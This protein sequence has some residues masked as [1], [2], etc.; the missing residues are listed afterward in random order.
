MPDHGPAV[1]LGIDF[2]LRRIGM[3]CGNT[4][5][6]TAQ[7]LETL[8]HDGAPFAALSRIIAQWQP[9]RIIV[10]LPLGTDGGETD[11]SGRTRRFAAELRERHPGL[12]VTLHDERFTSRAAGSRFAEARREG[13]ARRRDAGNLDSMAAA[14]IVESWLAEQVTA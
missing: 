12:A 2:G 8:H 11:L 14:M 13:R 9:D 3:A 10:G 4:L 5:T 7:P 1:V 6:G